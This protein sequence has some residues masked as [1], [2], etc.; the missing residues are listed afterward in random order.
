MPKLDYGPP[1][2][3]WKLIINL[4]EPP[5]AHLEPFGIILELIFILWEL[6]GAYS[7]HPEART[8]ALRGALRPEGCTQTDALCARQ[9]LYM[10]SD[11]HP[12]H[13]DKCCSLCTRIDAPYAPGQTLYAPGQKLYAPGQ[14]L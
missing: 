14:R 1:G 12:V 10:R 5:G 9:M 8:D 7:H 11:R 13:P 2:S 3:L 6:P 4:W